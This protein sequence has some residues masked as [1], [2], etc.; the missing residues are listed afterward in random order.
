MIGWR[1]VRAV[2][3]LAR[4]PRWAKVLLVVAAIALVAWATWTFIRSAVGAAL[5]GGASLAA[6]ARISRSNSTAGTQAAAAIQQRETASKARDA[7]VDAE[8]RELADTHSPQFNQVSEAVEPPRSRF[9]R[10]LRQ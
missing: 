3:A 10:R 1:G 2:Q 8:L 4:L 5:V 6:A 9:L 7:V